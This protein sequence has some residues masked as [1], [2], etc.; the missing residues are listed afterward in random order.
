MK[1]T[2]IIFSKDRTLQL[3]S[4][5]LSIKTNGDIPEQN[6]CV[7]YKNTI[8]EI[9]YD[10]LKDIFECNF[11][12]QGDFLQDLKDIVEKSESEFFE[13]MVDDLILRDRMS[14]KEIEEFMDSNPDIDSFCP[15]MGKNINC[16]KT[17]DFKN[18]GSF[19]IWDT[20][21]DLGKHWNYAWDLSSSLYRRSIVEEYLSKCRH[22]KETFPNPFESHY[23]SCMPSTKPL[24]V[25][26]EI[27]NAIR[28]IFRK[29]S[30][31]IAC[32]EKSRC[33]TQ[34]VNLVA[35]IEGDN[36]EQQ[37]DPITLH[38]KMMDGYV[39]DFECLKDVMNEQPN[40]GHQYFKLK[41]LFYKEATEETEIVD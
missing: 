9:S 40:A 35:D 24:P 13:F 2:I 15:R 20:S 11:I 23:F 29:K 4:L 7:I 28:F 21:Q 12:E 31:R 38:N 33:F 26:V 36:R 8:P 18:R 5:L 34:G 16:G 32:M 6:I 22:Q 3:K 19:L 41:K 14:W 27:V 10:H 25:H 30:M 1:T 17:P 37:F 39:I